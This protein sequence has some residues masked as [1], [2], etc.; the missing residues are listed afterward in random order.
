MSTS[1]I[2]AEHDRLIAKFGYA[3]SLHNRTH[4]QYSENNLIRIKNKDNADIAWW[5]LK[6]F[7]KSFINN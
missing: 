3:S 7:E 4:R 1:E 2:T 5:T 6:A